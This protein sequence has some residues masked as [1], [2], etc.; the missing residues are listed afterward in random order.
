VAITDHDRA[1]CLAKL[2]QLNEYGQQL[3]N[4]VTVIPAVE[5]TTRFRFLSPYVPH[6]ILLNVLA[7]EIDPFLGRI[8]FPFYYLSYYL[9]GLPHPEQ[10][11]EWI[12][13]FRQ[14]AD[15]D[16]LVVAAHPEPDLSERFPTDSFGQYLAARL[17]SIRFSQL[18]EYASEFDAIEILN[19]KHR[20]RLDEDRLALAKELGLPA[21]GGSD[22]HVAVNIGKVGTYIPGN[23]ETVAEVLRFIRQ[24]QAGTYLDDE[25]Y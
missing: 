21:I 11:F 12:D 22:A 24:C 19:L 20:L 2:A 4:P 6:I 23:V 5:I 9:T 17:T 10:L 1:L 18:M 3:K 25:K 14:Q 16:I 8:G 7:E 15:K 13:Q